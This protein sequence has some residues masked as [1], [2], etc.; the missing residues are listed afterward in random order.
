MFKGI[1]FFPHG[2]KWDVVGKRFWFVGL[3]WVLAIVAAVLLFTRGLNYGVD[4]KGGALIEIQ[5]KSGD[6]DI[7][8]IARQAEQA[9]SRRRAGAVGRQR[10]RG[11]DPRRPAAG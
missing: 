2:T 8:H 1:D 10:Q 4:F 7:G 3:S 11:A 5:S 6:L 9:R